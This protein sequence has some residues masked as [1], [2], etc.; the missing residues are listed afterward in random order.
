M[1]VRVGVYKVKGD[2]SK[3]RED[4]DDSSLLTSN[5]VDMTGDSHFEEDDDYEVDFKKMLESS[6]MIMEILRLLSR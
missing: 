5:L 1:G 6:R 3:E 4:Y 2:Y